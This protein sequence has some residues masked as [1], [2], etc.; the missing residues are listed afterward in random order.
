MNRNARTQRYSSSLALALLCLPAAGLA[1]SSR[2]VYQC[3]GS[4]NQVA[5]SAT[6]QIEQGG[7]RGGPYVAGSISNRITSYTFNGE[8][9]GGTEGYISLLEIPGG[10]RID[11]VW[12]G[13]GQSGFVLRTEDGAVFRFSCGG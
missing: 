1:Q 4:I 5:S 6:L 12:I 11:R 2:N 7:Y 10:Q 9:F 8:L 3:Q 13:I